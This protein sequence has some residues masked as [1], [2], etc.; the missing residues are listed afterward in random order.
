[1]N[2]RQFTIGSLATAG[3][4]LNTLGA[5]PKS[6]AGELG[7]DTASLSPHFSKERAA[8][9]ITLLDFPQLMQ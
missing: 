3:I 2:R 7:L 8:G 6:L 1:M 4:G 9:K 5:D